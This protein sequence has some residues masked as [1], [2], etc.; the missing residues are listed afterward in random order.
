MQKRHAPWTA[1]HSFRSS[2]SGSC[3]ARRRFPE[4][5]KAQPVSIQPK[6]DNGSAV[7]THEGRLSV[8]AQLVLLGALGDVFARLERACLATAH[9][10]VRSSV[11]RPSIAQTGYSQAKKRRHCVCCLGVIL[12][13][14]SV[15]GVYGARG[16]DGV[17]TEQCDRQRA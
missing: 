6:S 12:A 1:S 9:T 3:T 4:P 11:Q 2:P 14:G 5:C 8:F 7:P 17:A 15:G 16:G 10:A 13:G